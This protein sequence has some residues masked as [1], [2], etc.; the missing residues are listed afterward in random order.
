MSTFAKGIQMLLPDYKPGLLGKHKRIYPR[1]RMVKCPMD[2]CANLIRRDRN[3]T[4]R[5]CRNEL[6]RQIA[7]GI[8]GQT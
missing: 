1:P 2:G 3:K 6:R 8:G 4:C 7:D 5:Q